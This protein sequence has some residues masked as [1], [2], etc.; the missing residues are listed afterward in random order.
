MPDTVII[1]TLWASF[2]PGGETSYGYSKVLLLL[3]SQELIIVERVSNTIHYSTG[4]LQMVQR[5]SSVKI[6]DSQY[7][8]YYFIHHISWLQGCNRHISNMHLLTV[9]KEFL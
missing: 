1:T 2:T 3:S 4:P 7:I 6:C 9:F 5:A 8:P